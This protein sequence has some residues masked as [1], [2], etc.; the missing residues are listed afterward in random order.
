VGDAALA[1]VAGVI[2]SVIALPFFPDPTRDPVGLVA[3][4]LVQNAA[5]V[6]YL[7][8]VAHFRGR[9]SLRADF[10]LWL[11]LR[12]LGWIAIGMAIGIG[13]SLLLAPMTELHK[14]NHDQEVVHVAKHA[15]G[16]E[17]ALVV[18]GVVIV[19]PI[20][21]ELLFR[22]VLLR[23][24]LR[25]TTAEWAVLISAVVFA[26]VHLIDG[27]FGSLVAFPVL[28]GLGLFSGYQAV[29]TGSLSRSIFLHMGF[30]LLTVIV[31]FA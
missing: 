4:L 18:F 29:T 13:G 24:L 17:V 5:I 20:A 7:A 23:S 11:R 27:S 6:L 22:G 1:F 9:G 31:L 19:A 30:N 12:D 16:V 3:T 21:E 14:G 25:R 2:A 8:A 26:A 15:T 10:G 28:L